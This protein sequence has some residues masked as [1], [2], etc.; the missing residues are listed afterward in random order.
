MTGTMTDK[1][2]QTLRG[3]YP[4]DAWKLEGDRANEWTTMMLAIFGKYSDADV[5]EAVAKCVLACDSLPSMAVIRKAIVAKKSAVPYFVALPQSTNRIGKERIDV[6]VNA[7]IAKRNKKQ[8]AEKNI[9]PNDSEYYSNLPQGLIDFARR[10]FPD[11]SLKLIDKNRNEFDFVREQVSKLDGFPLGLRMDKK[12]GDIYT[13]V[14][15]P[16][17]LLDKMKH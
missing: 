17:S 6:I 14:G 1:I 11:I 10:K 2:L 4:N 8:E 9:D 3:S 12:T 13:V 16:Q 5:Y 7:A 15:Y